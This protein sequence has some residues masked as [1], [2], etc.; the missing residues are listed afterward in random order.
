MQFVVLDPHHFRNVEFH[1]DPPRVGGAQ[2]GAG[3]RVEWRFMMPSPT[4]NA[5][6]AGDEATDIR[7]LSLTLGLYAV[8]LAAKLIA[9][10]ATDVMAL[11][12]EA[13]HTLS[14]IFVSAFLLVAALYSRRQADATHMFG[15]GRAQNIAALVAAT[16][17]ISFT[18]FEL[19]RE[20]IP[21]LL[22]PAPAQYD[23]LPLALAVIVGSMLVAAVPLARMIIQKAGGAAARAQLLELVNDQLGLFAALIAILLIPLG[24][25]LADPIAAIVVAT[26]IAGNAVLLFRENASVLLGRSPGR[27]YLAN[28]ERVARSVPGVVAVRELRAEYVGTEVVHAGI[29]LEV[30]GSLTVA[31]GARIADEVRQRVHSA[32]PD[33]YCFIQIE[34]TT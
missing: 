5:R 18:S 21:R 8:I 2:P 19:Y 24:Y 30:D 20:A 1:G 12:A 16:L 27:E 22:E 10:V 13:L 25:P 31:D 7:N 14:D 32:A 3:D 29:R 28:V 9:W 15:Y 11:F 33:S 4:E 23:H 26:I 34:P 6:R 17:F